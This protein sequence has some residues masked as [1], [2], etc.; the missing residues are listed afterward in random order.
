MAKA[1][2]EAAVSI[3]KKTYAAMMLHLRNA[4]PEEG[5]GILLGNEHSGTVV[6]ISSMD[7]SIAEGRK[8]SHYLIDP[9]ELY[10]LETEGES[11]GM[12]VAGIYHSHPDKAAALSKEDK[13]GMIPGMLYL[14]VSTG[15]SGIGEI[16]GYRKDEPD[17]K[18]YGVSIEEA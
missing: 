13:L 16:K 7:N 17:G 15:E 8:A 14:V 18:I 2:N 10:K 3:S 5:C 6:G 9:I 12:T 1:E 4:Y 11:R